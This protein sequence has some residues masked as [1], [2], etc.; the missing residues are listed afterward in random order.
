MMTTSHIW[1]QDVSLDS[2]MAGSP[3]RIR[4]AAVLHCGNVWE[5]VKG[6]EKQIWKSTETE[7]RVILYNGSLWALLGNELL[8][9]II[10]KVISKRILHL[11]VHSKEG[12][13]HESSHEN[14]GEEKEYFTYL[15]LSLLITRISVR[16]VAT[17]N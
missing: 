15:T 13:I 14:H 6:A 9:A 4:S 17:N 1:R 12:F 11:P 2:I 7:S 16:L 10:W 3:S 8:V 5:H